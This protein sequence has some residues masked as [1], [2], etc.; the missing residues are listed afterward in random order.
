MT[1]ISDWAGTPGGRRALTDAA[2]LAGLFVAVALAYGPSLKH[3]PRADQWCFLVDTMDDHTFPAALRHTYSYN[4]TRQ[5]APGDTDLFRPLLF[6]LL[7]AEKTLLDGHLAAIQTVGV[8]LHCAICALLL[9]VLRQSRGL[10]RRDSPESPD[11]QSRCDLLMY[12]TVTFFALNPCVQELVIWSHLHGYLLFLLLAL[13]SISCLFRYAG[14]EAA[15]WLWAGWVLAGLAAFTYELGQVYALLAGAFVAVGAVPRL[16]VLR[17]SAVLGLFAA[18]PVGYQAWNRIDLEVHRGKY[19]PDNLSPLIAERMLT[20]E[21]AVHSARFGVY[22][23]VQPFF[24]SL[25]EASYSGQRL[26]IAET[27]WAGRKLKAVSPTLVVSFAALGLGLVLGLVGL[28]SHL[29]TRGRLG[30]LVVALPTML[31]AAYA[32]MAVLGRMNLRPGPA[33]LTANSYYAYTSLL[34]AL[35]AVSGL[36][37]AVGAWAARLRAALAITLLTLSAHGAE[38]VWRANT[39]VTHQDRDWSRPIRAVQDFV[40]AHRGEPGFGFTIDYAN[41]DTIPVVYS[42]PITEVV[43]REWTK[44]PNPPYRLTVRTGRAEA[45]SP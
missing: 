13:G 33:I 28:G 45:S 30:L 18:I 21:T 36:W 22:T 2:V 11:G 1:R 14:G 20:R 41:S 23:S 25:V 31:Y 17:A 37:H 27:V 6:V 12:A 32:G 5:V 7:A 38:L 34:F 29:R 39:M 43:F 10:V 35:L 4:R 8:V 44:H 16:R 9:V 15:R 42:R 3:A 24:P 19:V 40:D 26:Q